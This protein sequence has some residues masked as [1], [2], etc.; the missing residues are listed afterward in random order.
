M[1]LQRV[2]GSGGERSGLL[3]LDGCEVVARRRGC[4]LGGRVPGDRASDLSGARPAARLRLAVLGAGAD[5][6]VGQRIL[7][8]ASAAMTM[9]LYGHLFDHN[10]W[11][12]ADRVGGTTGARATV[13]PGN[14]EAPGE[15]RGLWPGASR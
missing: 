4:R 7:G 10:L 6:Q 14:A 11:A 2:L 15:V 1:R 5:P 8:H 13:G 9:D 12:A 3:G